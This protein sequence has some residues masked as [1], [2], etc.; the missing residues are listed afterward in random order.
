MSK[1]SPV[2]PGANTSSRN[3]YILIAAVGFLLYANTL[4]HGFVLDDVA[5]IQN[6]RFVTAGVKGIPDILTTFYWEGYWNSNAGLYRP[7]SLISFAIE[8]QL[9]PANPFIHHLFNVLYY[10]LTCCLLFEFLCRVFNKTDRRFFL[11]AVLLFIVH[12]IHTEVVANIKSRD[13]LFSLL[14]FLLCCRQLYV[15]PDNGKKR[16]IFSSLFFLLALLSKEGAIA[17]IPVIF[18][19]DYLD[20]KNIPALIKKR[21]ALLATTA[22]WFAWHQYIITSSSSPRITYTYSDNSLFASSSLLDQKATA[23]GMFARYIIKSFYPYTLSYDY[24]FNEIPIISFMSVPALCGLILFGALIWLAF[25]TLKTNPLISF[26]LAMIVLPLML[27]GNLFFNIGATMADRFLFIPTI[28]SCILICWCVFK[29]F[30]IDVSA[31]APAPVEYILAAVFLL[32]SV[33]SFT[34]NKDWKDDFTLF[35]TDVHHAPGS[36]RTHFN[37]ALV[38]EK[39]I[40]NDPTRAQKEYEV[41]LGIDPYYHDAILN[42]G[43]IYMKQANYTAAIKL[44][45]TDLGRYKNNPDALGNMGYTFYKMGQRDSAVYYLKKAELTGNINAVSCNVLGTLYFEKQNYPE[46]ISAYEKGIKKDS[47]NAEMYNNYG[48]VLAL[49]NQYQAA[50]KA[51]QSSYRAN[52]NKQALY[53]MAITYN[54]LGDTVNAYKYYAQFKKLSQ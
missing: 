16:L 51:F 25:K 3:Y 42:L 22:A 41:C 30:K 53:F 36:A 35:K 1:K 10:A 24:S 9:S 28:G 49:T 34:R 46:A 12:P 37:N 31:K 14:F 19:I 6:N 18:L 4:K 13:E 20:E 8:Y 44:Y 39:T 38:F 5:V 26:C 48:N 23:F 32:F 43:N 11:F 54:K 27:T 40:T 33:K 15:L 45:H 2:I 52:N 50:L 17:F 47:T 21:A 7:L 29:I